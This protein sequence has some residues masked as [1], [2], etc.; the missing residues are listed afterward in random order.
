MPH[1]RFL[2]RF[3]SEGLAWRGSF[4]V[5]EGGS[6]SGYSRLVACNVDLPQRAGTC[7]PLGLISSTLEASILDPGGIFGGTDAPPPN[8]AEMLPNERAEY[9]ALTV[10]ELEFRRK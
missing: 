7:D 4:D 10:R 3:Q 9:V 1:N 5:F 2:E 6:N 8:F